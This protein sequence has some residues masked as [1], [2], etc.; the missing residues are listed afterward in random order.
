MVTTAAVN[1]SMRIVKRHRQGEIDK[2]HLDDDRCA[3]DHFN[4]DQR[5]VVGYPTT[6][7]ACKTCQQSDHQTASQ[8]EDRN[9]QGHFGTFNQKRNG[10]PDGTPVKLHMLFLLPW[11]K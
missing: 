8:T 6:E 1:G 10:R 11:C 2:H 3:A 4:K 9:P 7:G 5:D